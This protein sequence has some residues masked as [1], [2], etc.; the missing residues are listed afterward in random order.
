LIDVRQQA[1]LEAVILGLHNNVVRVC[2]QEAAPV[3]GDSC[4]TKCHCTH[5]AHH[6]LSPCNQRRPHTSR[7]DTHVSNPRHCCEN[8]TRRTSNATYISAQTSANNATCNQSAE[9]ASKCRAN[10]WEQPAQKREGPARDA[11]RPTA[12]SQQRYC[13]TL[14]PLRLDTAD[15]SELSRVTAAPSNQNPRHSLA[16]V[17]TPRSTSQMLRTAPK[18]LRRGSVCRWRTCMTMTASTNDHR[19]HRYSQNCQTM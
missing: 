14:L 7:T 13:N 2:T 3:S 1:H 4:Y 9:R 10:T 19:D 6:A 11:S 8:S 17:G 15:L 12:Q 18:L 5:R 16:E